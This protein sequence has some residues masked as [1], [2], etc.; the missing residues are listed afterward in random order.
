MF[1][2]VAGLRGVVLAGLPAPK[3]AS[4]NRSFKPNPLRPICRHSRCRSLAQHPTHAL[5]VGLIPVLGLMTNISTA[6]KAI[7]SQLTN[8]GGVSQSFVE[9]RDNGSEVIL[10]GNR[11]GLL[12]IALHILA[13]AERGTEGSHFHLDPHSGAD[14]AERPLV[15]RRS[16]ANEA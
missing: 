2:L 14:V 3:A 10:G 8:A 13:L 1:R 15:L 9:V 11:A 12:Q 6:V 7:E 4:P 5:W 16:T